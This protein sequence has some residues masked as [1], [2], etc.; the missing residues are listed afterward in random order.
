[1][2]DAARFPQ[3]YLW[4]TLFVIALAALI[5][6]CTSYARD[7]LYAPSERALEIPE[8]VGAA[9]EEVTVATEDGLTLPGF[10]W[11]P[12]EGEHDVILVLHGRRDTYARMAGYVQRLSQDGRGVLVA[13]YR[14]FNGN[15][16]SPSQAGLITDAQAFFRL[17]RERAGV[18]R[19]GGGDVYVFGHSLGGG[20]AFQLAA[21]EELAGVI[22]LGTFTNI[23]A[24]APFYADPFI[25][26]SWRS[27][28]TL[29]EITEPL[30]LIH[31]A[32]DDYVE[33]GNSRELFAATCS[34]AA[35]AIIAGVRHKPNFRLIQPIMSEWIEATEA[36]AA[37]QETLQRSASWEHKPACAAR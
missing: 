25:P 33:P 29:A 35:L 12:A 32:E 16:G 36:G 28:A 10:Y 15:P 5:N 6:G 30:L 7:R 20:I 27:L 9:P 4:L 23:E 2:D 24:V 3:R 1:M 18:G 8:W 17:A 22:T 19:D 37:R 26:D 21:R 14:G 11:A 31:G 34:N 13:S